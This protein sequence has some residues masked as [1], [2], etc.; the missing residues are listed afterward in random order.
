MRGSDPERGVAVGD[1]VVHLKYDALTG[2]GDRFVVEGRAFF[3]LL[4]SSLIRFIVGGID[5]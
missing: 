5:L 4:A 1:R 3:C 2:T